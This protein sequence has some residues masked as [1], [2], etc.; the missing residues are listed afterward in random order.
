MDHARAVLAAAERLYAA[1]AM[2]ELWPGAL[3][4]VV[5]SIRG[6][7]GFLHAGAAGPTL[8]THA[9]VDE[10]DVARVTTPEALLMSEPFHRRIPIGV[11]TRNEFVSDADFARSRCYNEL[12]RPLHG[13]HSVHLYQAN[14]ASFFTLTICRDRHADNFSAEELAQVRAVEPHLATALALRHRLGIAEQWS[15][16]LASTLD[17][18]DTGVIL[19][20]AAAR[21][22]FANAR[23]RQILSAGDGL[24]H[25]GDALIATTPVAT[26]RLRQALMCASGARNGA[27][28]GVSRN[29]G[30]QQLRLE[31]PSGR[32]PLLLTILPIWRLDLAAGGLPAPRAAV[33]VTEADTPRAIDRS[34]VADTFRLTRRE[35]EVA[36]LL[37]AGCDLADIAARLGLGINTVRTH[38]KRVFHKTDVHSQ[39][40]LMALIRGFAAPFE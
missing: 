11:I 8:V 4:A 16:G 20:D 31:R 35:A 36:L 25:Q 39:T 12:F 27:H 5:D 37:A 9:R 13:F 10:R 2:P 1:V 22:V 3:D 19:T 30:E 15:H 26:Q 6:G 7:H 33:F 34:A 14:A 40:A 24:S 29:G 38:L 17:R 28:D 23:A 32:A 21:P 18:L